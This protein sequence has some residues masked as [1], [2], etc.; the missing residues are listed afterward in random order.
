MGGHATSPLRSSPGVTLLKLVEAERPKVMAEIGVD[1]GRSMRFV[2]RRVDFVEQYWAVDWWSPEAAEQAPFDPGSGDYYHYWKKRPIAHWDKRYYDVLKY[3]PWFPALR[4]V[5]APSV[6]MARMFH[7]LGK[8]YFNLVFIDAN[9][10]YESVVEDI[11]AWLPLIKDGGVI[12]GH[13]YGSP[14]HPG[15]GRAVDE[16]FGPTG[17][18]LY[19]ETVWL[20]R[21]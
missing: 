13:D 4:V 18:E 15:V 3:M 5:R 9:H 1:K 20:K 17:I 8:P 19:P 6:V 11:A 14:L 21:L 7:Q 2:L 16:I 12:C 10:M